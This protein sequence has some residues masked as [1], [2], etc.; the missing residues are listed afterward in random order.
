MIIE[1]SKMSGKEFNTKIDKLEADIIQDRKSKEINKTGQRR[2]G[3]FLIIDKRLA[4]TIGVEALPTEN[5]ASYLLNNLDHYSCRD[6]VSGAGASN[7]KIL[8]ISA[9]DFNKA[10]K[11]LHRNAEP[12]LSVAPIAPMSIAKPVAIATDR[13]TVFSILDDCLK[14]GISYAKASVKYGMSKSAIGN[15]CRG[16]RQVTIVKEWK[17][18][19]LA[20]ALCSTRLFRSVLDVQSAGAK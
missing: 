14:F 13:E 10:R 20:P 4:A 15:L 5:P 7:I 12:L 6:L 16:E 11:L 19:N 3:Y 17:D 1:R 2:L 18:K 8:G 9:G